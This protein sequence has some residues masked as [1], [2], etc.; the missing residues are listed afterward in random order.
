MIQTIKAT[1]RNPDKPTSIFSLYPEIE[2]LADA[3]G[4][5]ILHVR[6][7]QDGSGYEADCCEKE[8]SVSKEMY[9]KLFPEPKPKEDQK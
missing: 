2:K 5:E 4:L 9:A 3:N 8:D 6:R 7:C 1:F